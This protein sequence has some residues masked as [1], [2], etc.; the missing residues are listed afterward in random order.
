MIPNGAE[1]ENICGKGR[2]K[3]SI[4]ARGHAV[5]S[6]GNTSYIAVRGATWRSG[7]AADCKS[8]YPGSI[9]GVASNLLAKCLDQ[10]SVASA[11]VTGLG[12][13]MH[14]LCR[15]ERNLWELQDFLPQR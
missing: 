14:S 4:G 1:A 7:D 9:P 10:Q 2:Q 11:N 5:L 8:A 12:K 15:C 13:D 3:A 6:I